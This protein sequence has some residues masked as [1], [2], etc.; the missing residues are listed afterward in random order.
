[1]PELPEVESIRRQLEPLVTGYYVTEASSHPSGKFT[2]AREVVG[3]GFE[4]ISRRGKYLLFHLDNAT[5]MVVHLGM[6]GQLLPVTNLS[7][8][9]L[10]A[11]WKFD[12]NL[13][14][15]YRDIR[16]FG[17]I[18]IYS[19]GLYEGTLGSLGP[20]PLSDDFTVEQFYASL[21]RSNRKIKT[22]LLSQ[23]PVAGIG[24]IYADEACFKAGIY[25]GVRQLTK[26]QTGALHESIRQVLALAVENGGTTLRDYVNAEGKKGKNQYYLACYGR[27]GE[28]CVEC[29]EILRRVIID[30]RGT[31]FCKS[32][33]QR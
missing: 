14:L 23:R 2:P 9:Y 33:Q 12:S 27:D 21:K 20:E 31:T 6:T 4:A 24:N 15:G 7:D 1:M 26:S 19:P 18:R 8:P 30:G 16:R 5:E 10:R 28:P 32:C 17:R 11:W 22:Q 13:I 29:G 3:L 25:P